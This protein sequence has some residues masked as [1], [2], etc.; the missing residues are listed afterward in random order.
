MKGSI[1]CS[2]RRPRADPYKRKGNTSKFKNGNGEQC[3]NSVRKI[4]SRKTSAARLTRGNVSAVSKVPIIHIFA[5]SMLQI[6]LVLAHM[7]WEPVEWRRQHTE[8]NAVSAALSHAHIRQLGCTRLSH[9]C[10]LRHPSRQVH[11][12]TIPRAPGSLA[13]LSARRNNCFAALAAVASFFSL[14]V[15]K[16]NSSASKRGQKQNATG[17]VE[18]ETAVFVRSAYLTRF[19][20]ASLCSMLCAASFY[21]VAKTR[22][23]L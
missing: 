16:N 5:N 21:S 19:D 7:R 10:A 1:S 20:V 17:C 11:I 18:G 22:L 3:V 2:L 15:F 14:A 9:R 13:L 4:H 8:K 23:C 12:Q 6:R